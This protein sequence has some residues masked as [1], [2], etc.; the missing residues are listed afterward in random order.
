MY[1]VFILATL[2]ALIGPAP[3]PARP[4]R[5]GRIDADDV[6][7]LAATPAPVQARRARPTKRIG[8][9]S[10]VV[11][12]IPPTQRKGRETRYQEREGRAPNQVKVLLAALRDDIKRKGRGYQV[13]YTSALERPDD[14][15]MGLAPSSQPLAGALAHNAAAIRRVG[16]NDL[17]NRALQRKGRKTARYGRQD[18]AKDD[19]EGAP[20][21]NQQG[22]G[23]MGPSGDFAELCSQSAPA[24]SWHS[25]LSPVRDQTTCGSC[26]AFAAMGAFEASHRLTNNVGLDLSE[27]H[28]VDCARSDGEDAG[29]CKGG[30]AERVHK[31]LSS[32]GAVQTESE[33][34]YKGMD[35]ACTNP[36][37]SYSALAW[38]WVD[39]QRAN[40]PV[41]AVKAAICKYGPV[42]ASV[43]VT[44]G[45]KS[46]VSGVF[47]ESDSGETN[48]AIV[49]VGWDDVRGAWLLRN[50]WGT[51]WGE[52]GYM[53]IKYGSNSVGKWATWVAVEKLPEPAPPTQTERLLV[54]RN[55]SGTPLEVSLQSSRVDGGARVWS[56]SPPGKKAKARTFQLQPGKSLYVSGA[57][58]EATRADRIRVF[59]RAGAKTWPRWWSRDLNIVASGGYVSEDIEPLTYTFFPNGADSVPAPEERDL[60]YNSGREALKAKKYATA[61]AQLESWSQVF[62]DDPRIGTA[63]YYVGVAR[64]KT[65]EH[66]TAIEWLSR[67]QTKEPEHPWY[68]YASYW[69]G[70]AYADLGFC[71]SALPY[72]EAV[73]WTD[74]PIS[75]SFRTAALDNVNRLNQDD[76]TICNDWDW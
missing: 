67:M 51:D 68:V 33:R 17:L 26:W 21:P 41:D 37:G 12:L 69:L 2:H 35:Q 15:L 54:F 64:L 47:D 49:L 38:G 74:Q 62:S 75:D 46:Y 59:A 28:V 55:E 16:H 32:G 48:H 1:T 70:E 52:D 14:Q 45:F 73:A 20:P 58:S 44:P 24:F 11:T 19:S 31:W 23:Q 60:A 53:W 65:N 5:Q 3:A 22:G 13:G 71:G 18:P 66:W 76:G 72:F 42:T 25:H 9:S 7:T 10:K 63:Y 34:P 36:S 4:A 30:R 61:A 56:P 6:P 8:R 27:Q 43:R 40:P 29:S 39:A 50:S 57:D